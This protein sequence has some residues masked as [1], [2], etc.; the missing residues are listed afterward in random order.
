M[1]YF[2]QDQDNKRIKIGE[3]DDPT[4]RIKQILTASSAVNGCEILA[5]IPGGKKREDELHNKFQKY[6]SHREWFSESQELVEYIEAFISHDFNICR[7]CGSI[8]LSKPIIEDIK[9]HARIH[10]TMRNGVLPYNMRELLKEIGWGVLYSKEKPAIFSDIKKDDAKR[11]I[12]FSWWAR[13]MQNGISEK[14]FD[15]FMLDQFEYLDARFGEAGNYKE[16]NKRNQER[17]GKFN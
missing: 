7:V 1:I 4:N 13:S 15:D 17:W 3:S 2:I 12:A 6:H 16:L 8:S 9:G 5:V 14:W 10:K 11:L